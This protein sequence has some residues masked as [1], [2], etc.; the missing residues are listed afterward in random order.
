MKHS[1]FDDKDGLLFLISGI[2]VV[3]VVFGM[4]LIYGVR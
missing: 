4:I 2:I 3:L 1:R